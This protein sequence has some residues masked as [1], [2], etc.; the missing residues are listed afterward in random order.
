MKTL[1]IN[2]DRSQDRL[3]AQHRQFAALGLRFERLPAVTVADIDDEYYQAHLTDW[4]RVMKQSEFACLFSHRDAWQ[5]VADRDE[6]H[7]ILEDDA[8]LTQD[9]ANLLNA[10]EQSDA[11]TDFINLE[12]HGRKKIIGSS[13]AL[14]LGGEYALHPLLMDKSGT[15]GYVLYPSGARKLLDHLQNGIGLADFFIYQCPTLH[16]QQLEPA[17][18]LQSDKCSDY[19]VPFHAYP[20]SSMIG[21]IS[22]THSVQLTTSQ[23]LT[24]KKNRIIAQLTL[25]IRTLIALCKGT[26][27]MITVRAEK[28]FIDNTTQDH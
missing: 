22:N 25:G 13:S 15:G 5:I 17:A 24:L 19:G 8:V 18:V 20:L 6:P 11:D 2:L 26:K 4:Q 23:K 10:I 12:A 16:K 27:R 1:I 7:L 9:F 21:A 28:F 14:L 3:A